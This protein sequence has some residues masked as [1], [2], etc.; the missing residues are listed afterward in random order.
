M[1]EVVAQDHGAV[2]QVGAQVEEV[3]VGPADLLHP[4]RHHLHVA[5]R[6]GDGDGVFLE[7]AFV[8]DDRQHE[9]RV[10]SG[11]R[12]FVVDRGQQLAPL[13]FVRHFVRDARR[14]LLDPRPH[15]GA[16]G[17]VDRHGRVGDVLGQ[18]DDHRM[19]QLLLDLRAGA[20]P[21]AARARP[22]PAAPAGSSG[23]VSTGVSS[24]ARGS[25]SRA[26]GD[27]SGQAVAEERRDVRHRHR[28]RRRLAAPLV[29]DLALLQPAIADRD[30]MRN[31]DQLEISKHHARTLA[32]V[33]Q[34]HFHARGLEFVVQLVGQRLDAFAAIVADGGD[35]HGERRQRQRAR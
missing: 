17:V 16:V 18:S 27:R 11:A 30:A 31:A 28:R 1:V 14:H 33:V 24:M 34:Q 4:E 3:L 2:A 6:V 10:E 25:S 13:A 22:R 7:A 5:A 12:C 20:G 29:F 8:I 9:L 19:R 21:A 15:V 23:K 35:G 26:C 32:A